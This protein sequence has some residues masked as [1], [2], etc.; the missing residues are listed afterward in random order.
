MAEIHNA[1]A[2]SEIG[3]SGVGQDLVD[4]EQLVRGEDAL[5]SHALDHRVGHREER[6]E[7]LALAVLDRA[8]RRPAAGGSDLR[9]AA[10]MPHG[11]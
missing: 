10:E 2:N 11:A 1:F 9:H 6:G 8:E 4:P 3:R 7:P 5:A